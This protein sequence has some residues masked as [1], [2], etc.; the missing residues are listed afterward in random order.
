M[1]TDEER[2]EELEARVILWA[3]R[4]SARQTEFRAARDVYAATPMV[5]WD[6]LTTA[7]QRYCRAY[8]SLSAGKM[9]LKHYVRAYAKLIPDVFDVVGLETEGEAL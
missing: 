4:V 9:V 7:F 3:N 5:P 8:S 2:E 6:D 1:A